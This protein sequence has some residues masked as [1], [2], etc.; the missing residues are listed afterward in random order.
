[1]S[2]KRQFFRNFFRRKYFKNHDI[3][4]RLFLALK[5][6]K[7]GSFPLPTLSSQLEFTFLFYNSAE[8]GSHTF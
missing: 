2:Q 4:P 5:K 8:K 6:N 3:G 7:I 1:M